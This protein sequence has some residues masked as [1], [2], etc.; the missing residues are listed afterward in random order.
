MFSGTYIVG[1]VIHTASLT[2]T[3]VLDLTD[4][5]DTVEALFQ[6]PELEQLPQKWQPVA[7]TLEVTRNRR[8]RR[9]LR[10]VTMSKAS[11]DWSLELLPN[12]ACPAPDALLRLVQTLTA[13]IQ[14]PPLR[15]FLDHAFADQQI[16]LPFIQASASANCHHTEPGGLLRHTV[17]MVEMLAFTLKDYPDPLQR[18]CAIVV[19][20]FHD[21]GKLAQHIIGPTPFQSH[22]HS[23]LNIMLLQGALLEL[24][25]NCQESWKLMHFMLSA[26]NGNIRTDSIPAAALVQMLDRYSAS[27]SAMVN[28]FESLPKSQ[29]TAS[30]GYH[31]H[32]PTRHFERSRLTNR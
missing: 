11:Q 26:L 6:V 3:V 31:P 18:Q 25:Q 7:C 17:D 27:T 29:L 32:Y 14:H 20:L 19:G 8:F 23:E 15:R 2:N 22:Q 13:E 21:L 9:Y 16:S 30:L 10:V 5:S 28:A 24:R 1:D 12:S 4:H